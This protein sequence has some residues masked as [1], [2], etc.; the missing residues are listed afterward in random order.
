MSLM[1]FQPTFKDVK[2]PEKGSFPLDHAGDQL[3]LFLQ[4]CW[5][6]VALRHDS[7]TLTLKPSPSP[8]INTNPNPT[9]PINPNAKTWP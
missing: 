4:Q 3:T 5:T 6:T 2:P 8:N 1:N 9:Y 7:L